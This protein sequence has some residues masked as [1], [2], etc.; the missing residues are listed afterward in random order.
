MSFPLIYVSIFKQRSLPGIS[1]FEINLGKV[2]Y[3]KGNNP[4]MGGKTV[5]TKKKNLFERKRCKT[6]CKLKPKSFGISEQKSKNKRSLKEKRKKLNQTSLYDVDRELEE[7]SEITED[8][9]CAFD[10]AL[11]V[12]TDSSL[13]VFKLGNG[14][15]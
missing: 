4:T 2:C 8:S 7:S 11:K 9:S 15:S 12:I 6:L 1:H 3:F 14:C 5:A 10:D 13:Y